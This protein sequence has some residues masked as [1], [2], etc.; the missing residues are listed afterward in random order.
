MS[1]NAL[2]V[3]FDLP[4]CSLNFGE[5]PCTATGTPCFNTRNNFHDCGDPA[6][7]DSATLTI[8]FVLNNGQNYWPQDDVPTF[9]I[10]S[11][12]S[13]SG[14]NID[15]AESMGSR[16]KCSITLNNCPSTMSGLDKNII[17]RDSDS[18]YRGTFLGKFKAINP[19][20][21]GSNVR[22]YRGD[23][24]GVFDVE[25]YTIDNF[26][27]PN[28]KGGMRFDCV[29]ALKLTNGD[30]SNFPAPNNGVLVAD[31]DEVQTTFDVSPVGVGSEYPA[32]GRVAIGNE[33]MGFTR[34]GDTFTVVR[35]GVNSLGQVEDHK[36]GDTVQFIGEYS[37]Q[38]SADI[39]A[40]LVTNYTPL[41]ASLI[42]LQ[43]WQDEINNF[44]NSLFSAVIV[45][46]VSV[47]KLINELIQQ[48]GLIFWFDVRANKIRLK[49]LRPVVDAVTLTED[50]IAGGLKQSDNQRV[51]VSQ[52]WTYFNQ[53][54]PF[55][56]L[57][58]ETNYYSTL[59]SPTTDNLYLTES[60]RKI[61]SR[62]IPLGGQAN[63]VELNARLIERYQNPP[64]DVSF[65]LQRNKLVS[66]GDSVLIE[67]R[68]IEDG[69]GNIQPK[70]CYVTNISPDNI[71]KS[72]KAKEFV[73]TE[74]EGPGG[75]SDVVIAIEQDFVTDVNLRA[76]YDTIRSSLAG[77]LSVTF[78]VIAGTVVGAS[79]NSVFGISVGDF[80][81]VPVTLK[82]NNGA[83]VLGA[84]GN[85]VTSSA[86]NSSG[87]G[88]VAINADYPITIENNGIIGG[89]GG[90]GGA[91]RYSDFGTGIGSTCGAGFRLGNGAVSMSVILGGP[92][93]YQL[94]GALYGGMLAD[95]LRS[96]VQGVRGAG[97]SNFGGGNGGD[98]GQS[99]S[100]G[101]IGLGYNA[102]NAINNNTNITWTNMGDIRGAIT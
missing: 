44:Q 82:I 14:A 77:V 75:G 61:H 78:D 96:Y 88:G 100:D 21:F 9:T 31:I 63:A 73:F 49:V 2:Y 102:G 1:I 8:R 38:T 48:A 11:G 95:D 101:D 26:S 35:N 64:L 62:W 19:Y 5:S 55:K 52:V 7:Y 25:H 4:Y 12:A 50:S 94:S 41:D 40:D 36:A 91:G 89:G 72:V 24:G 15:P 32:S 10:L 84:A 3:E 47:S 51:R 92:Q 69:F 28:Y 57:D 23:G 43:D 37:S 70:S 56:K 42:P 59:I 79:T 27:G 22:V 85:A 81:G 93:Y 97:F 98:L 17:A 53:K 80:D 74:Y 87:N 46:P 16:A 30:S 60:I 20:I 45:K 68:A 33:G 18:F 76:L 66:P 71:S 13:S 34:S 83:A 6:N 54:N 65:S 29:D 86:F 39:I 58:D 99:G 67:H 90:A